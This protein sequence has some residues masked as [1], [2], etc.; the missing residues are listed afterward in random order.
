MK[1]INPDWPPHGRWH[2]HNR[3]NW[4][5]WGIGWTAGG[6]FAIWTPIRVLLFGQMR[7]WLGTAEELDKYVREYAEANRKAAIAADKS[8]TNA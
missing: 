5:R 3:C 7:Q 4:H 6:Q 1:V 8:R 2:R